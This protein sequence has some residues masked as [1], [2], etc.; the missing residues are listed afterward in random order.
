MSERWQKI[1]KWIVWLVIAALFIV[2]V[3][4]LSIAIK[5]AMVEPITREVWMEQLDRKSVV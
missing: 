4:D 1:F 2:K 3:I 5:D